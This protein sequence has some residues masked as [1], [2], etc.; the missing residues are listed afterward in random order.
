M[1]V[2]I[3]TRPFE[4]FVSPQTP[5]NYL[6]EA[7][8]LKSWLLTTDH[9]RIGILYLFSIICSSSLSLRLLPR[10][11]ARNSSRPKAISSRPKP[12]TNSS[13]STASSWSG[14]F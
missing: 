11:F 12:T 8:T 10:S 3:E 2:R 9:K 7:R 4:P 13:P 6:T 1:S 5:K 14:F